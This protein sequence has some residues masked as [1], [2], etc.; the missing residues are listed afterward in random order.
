MQMNLLEHVHTAYVHKRR[1]SILR[2]HLAALLPKDATVLDVGC[3][4]GLLAS[5]IMQKR[6]DVI[7]KGVDILG[8][9]QTQIPVEWFDGEVIPYGDR[10]FEVT[11]FV[12]VLH[13]T[14]DPMILLHEAVR[15]ARKAVIVK[16]HTSDG[17][18]DDLTLRLMDQVGNARHGV[19]LPYN[20]WSEQRWFEAVDTLGLRITTWKKDLGLYPRPARWLFDRS[21][22]FV[23]RLELE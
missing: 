13:H 1:T 12:D 21:L 4:D 20:Y 10:S 23:S 19:A 16:D 2:D 5:L 15:V 6:P 3:G 17:L 8:R 7:I 9:S 14:L 18:L 11:M 22:H